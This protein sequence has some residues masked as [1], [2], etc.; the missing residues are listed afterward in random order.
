MP[1]YWDKFL[2]ELRRDKI[3]VEGK[4]A[5]LEWLSPAMLLEAFYHWYLEKIQAAN[6]SLKQT[7]KGA[8]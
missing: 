5:S 3:T 6:N 8:A 4:T 7:P 2:D 1:T